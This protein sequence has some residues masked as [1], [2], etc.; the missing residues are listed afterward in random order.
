M[1]RGKLYI[2]IKFIY[3]YITLTWLTE[4]QDAHLDACM[5]LYNYGGQVMTSLA[6]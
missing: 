6:D 2:Y 5:P 1:E 4:G 3:I